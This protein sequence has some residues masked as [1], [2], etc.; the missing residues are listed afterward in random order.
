[1]LYCGDIPP[2]VVINEAVELAKTFSTAQAPGFVNAILDSIR[3]APKNIQEAARFR[4]GTPS[5]VYDLNTDQIFMFRDKISS[6]DNAIQLALHEMFHKGG[7]AAFGKKFD[8]LL[9]DLYSNLSIKYKK[10]IAQIRTEYDLGDTK[11]GNREATEE[12]VAELA[13]SD[14]PVMKANVLKR[15]VAAVR[16]M[17]RDAG[18]VQEWTD[19]DIIAMISEAHESLKRSRAKPISEINLTEEVQVEETGEVF[20]IETNAEVALQQ[21]DKRADVVEKLRACL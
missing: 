21:H 2:S 8:V 6:V 14:S 18:F 19:N 9:D 3:D 20:D 15:F 7:R 11:L 1:M 13:Q 17:L 12:W 10:Q 16:K 5:G 4:K